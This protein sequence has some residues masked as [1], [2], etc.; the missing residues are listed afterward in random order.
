VRP[1]GPRARLE[2]VLWAALRAVDAAAAVRAALAPVDGELAIA[3]RPLARGQRLWVLAV[4]KA[5]APMAAALETVA[6]PRIAG[7]LAVTK[8]GHGAPLR[9]IELCEAGHPVPDARAER[10]ARR[11]LA[12]VE[13]AAPED[14]LVVLLSG[15]ASSLIA[16]PAPGLSLDDVAAVTAALLAS[17]API[18]EL[19]AVRKHLSAVAGGRLGQRARC[20]RIDVLAISDVPG[21]R[22]DVIGS[23][24]FAPDSSTASEARAV[25]EGRGLWGALPRNVVVHFEALA[26]GAVAD[27]PGPGDPGLARVRTTLLARNADAVAAAASE[28]SRRGMRAIVVSR[29]LAGEARRVGRVL[30]ALAAATADI[31]APICLIA[32]GE[33]TVTLQGKGSGGR[34]QELA[35]AAALQL[36]GRERISLL[37][38]GT[39]G[40]DGPTDAAGAFADGATQ[41]RGRAR[42]L[43]AVAALANNDSNRFFAGEGGLVVTGPTGTNVMD[44]VLALVEPRRG[45]GA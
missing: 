6:G 27:T 12:L 30:A 38:A 8:D 20:D 31:D 28:A 2:G 17:G 9:G 11:A 43:D 42:G 44:L 24:P 14:A 34:N 15:G 7:G 4:G 3:G 26:S 35:L 40:S 13:A 39:D 10:A 45:F 32:G 22:L 33:T 29:A 5:A 19:N 41:A 16:C 23:G 1:A 37:A 18:D 36:A 25:L 21:D